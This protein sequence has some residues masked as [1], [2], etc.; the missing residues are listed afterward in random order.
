MSLS[1][2]TIVFTGTLT[3][4]RADATKAA[5]AAGAKVSGSVSKNTSILVAGPGAGAKEA[6]AKAKGVEI[7]TEEQFTAVIGGGSAATLP[8]AAVGNKKAASSKALKA[9]L[10]AAD[11][12]PMSEA[13]SLNGKTIVFTG[14]LTMKRADATKAAEAAGAKVSG[15]VSKNTS[16]LVAG[17]GA[18]AKEADAK[19]KGV[20]IWTEEQFTAV[21]GGGSAGPPPAAAAGKKKAASSAADDEPTAK[22]QKG[23]KA[24]AEPKPAPPASPRGLQLHLKEPTSAIGL[25]QRFRENGWYTNKFDSVAGLRME[26]FAL[27]DVEHASFAHAPANA[28][29]IAETLLSQLE[30]CYVQGGE[31]EDAPQVIIISGADTTSA[32]GIKKACLRG[33][34]LRNASYNEYRKDQMLWD[35]AEVE[36]CDWNTKLKVGFDIEDSD[37]EEEGDRDGV[38]LAT[39]T[40]ARRLQSHFLFDLSSQHTFVPTIFGGCTKIDANEGVIVGVLSTKVWT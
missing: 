17:P 33:L 9:A 15:S 19:A 7:W 4:K 24:K 32:A 1:G 40:L 22:K 37:D 18:G 36:L 5:E 10:L 23:G 26:S 38:V 16:I 28:V 2:K 34:G 14:T 31:S 11:D 21:I 8:A 35:E 39:A 20:Q 13:M 12:E 6:D 27:E 3:M 30:G 29:A 25:A